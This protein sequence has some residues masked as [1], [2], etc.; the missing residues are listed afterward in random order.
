[1]LFWLLATLSVAGSVIVIEGTP[2]G[3]V[4]KC[5]AV[6]SYFEGQGFPATDIPKDPI[7]CTFLYDSSKSLI[8]INK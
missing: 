6:R 2:I 4:L 1:M 5:D 8:L 3:Q 7:L